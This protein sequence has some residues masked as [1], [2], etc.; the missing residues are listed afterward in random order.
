MFELHKA[1]AGYDL[2]LL[3]QSQRD[4]QQRVFGPVADY[5]AESNEVAVLIIR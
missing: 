5:V 1:A 2:A 3:G 4:I